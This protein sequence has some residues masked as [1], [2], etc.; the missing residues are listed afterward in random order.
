MK[1]ECERYSLILLT[2]P[3]IQRIQRTI[4]RIEKSTSSNYTNLEGQQ[5]RSQDFSKGG[6]RGEGVAVTMSTSTSCF[7]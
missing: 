1:S 6:E 7:T 2:S 4:Q 3:T 5:G